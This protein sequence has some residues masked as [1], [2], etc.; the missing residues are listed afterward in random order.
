ALTLPTQPKSKMPWVLGGVGA[1]V[2]LGGAAVGSTAAN[3]SG[4]DTQ[5]PPG[6][7]WPPSHWGAAGCCWG[8]PK[9][10]A[11]EMYWVACCSAPSS[12]CWFPYQAGCCWGACAGSCCGNPLSLGWPHPPVPGCCG[13]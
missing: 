12:V 4:S 13:G 5:P 11:G 6:G 9:P 7:N 8:L 2:V 10:A 1:V 3:P